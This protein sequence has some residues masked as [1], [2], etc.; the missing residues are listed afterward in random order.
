MVPSAY[1]HAQFLAVS[2]F[3]G[4]FIIHTKDRP[5][6]FFSLTNIKFEQHCMKTNKRYREHR[7]KKRLPIIPPGHEHDQFLV[8][9]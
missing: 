4:L 7:L 3:N 5:E 6:R 2:W 1:K 8:V 9:T